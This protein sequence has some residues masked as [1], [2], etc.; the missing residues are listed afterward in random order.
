MDVLNLSMDRA[1]AILLVRTAAIV[2]GAYLLGH[3]ANALIVGRLVR[4]ASRTPGNWDDVVIAELRRRLPFWSVLAGLSIALG[5]WDLSDRALTFTT[6]AI[7]ALAIGSLTIALSAVTTRLVAAYGHRP[8]SSA[9]VSALTQ[10]IARTVIIV[11]GL[12]VV[13]REFGFE[14][15]PYL[16]ALGVGGLAVALAL[17]DPLSNLFGGIFVSISGH[18]YIGDY[19]RVDP[20]VEGYIV[21]FDWRTTRI[22]ML[23]NNI[24][25]VPN[26][27]LAQAIVVNF[28]RP[29][30]E[31]AIGVEVQV[32]YANDLAKVERVALDVARNVMQTVPGSVSDADASVKFQAFGPLGVTLAV[33]M[34]GRTFPDQFTVRHEFMKQLHARFAQEGIAFGM[35]PK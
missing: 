25:T 1:S 16:A 12:L 28:S 15:T 11:L 29:T 4:L 21:D 18:M 9:P 8:G 34:K 33:G 13:A 7:R 14:I 6:A 27:K 2:G 5:Q 26:A 32:D 24:V 17:Q 23:S 19:V 35:T 31:V 30:T 22:R 3:L 10:N 20:G